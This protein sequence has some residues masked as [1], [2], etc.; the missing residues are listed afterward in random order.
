MTAMWPSRMQLNKNQFFLFFRNSS[1]CGQV[2][3]NPMI[4]GFCIETKPEGYTDHAILDKFFYDSNEC[5]DSFLM[6]KAIKTPNDAKL[7]LL[8]NSLRKWKLLENID[9]AELEVIKMIDKYK[10]KME[11]Q[12]D[13]LRYVQDIKKTIQALEL[14]SKGEILETES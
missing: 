14:I 4:I 7:D 13:L 9:K 2:D 1:N 5:H 8:K 12:N 6:K 3:D 11:F 10:G